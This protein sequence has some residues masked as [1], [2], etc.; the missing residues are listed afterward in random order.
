MLYTIDNNLFVS[1]PFHASSPPTLLAMTSNGLT[2][3]HS[4]SSHIKIFEL[5][6]TSNAKLLWAPVSLNFIVLCVYFVISL[7]NNDFRNNSSSL[8][9]NVDIDFHWLMFQCV[10][11][12]HGQHMF[13]WASKLST[14][15]QIHFYSLILSIW[16]SLD[17]VF[18][19]LED[20]QA[21]QPIWI[22]S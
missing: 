21:T 12:V 6:H 15:M 8:F 3:W 11:C 2:S 5:I 17:S 18:S 13:L 10:V 9:H 14:I 19:M 4:V 1:P 22:S 7:H 20:G 16:Q